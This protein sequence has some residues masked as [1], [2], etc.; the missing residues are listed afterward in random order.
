MIQR[1]VDERAAQLAR[2]LVST[3]RE[4][5]IAL[6][7][8]LAEEIAGGALA[9]ALLHI[10]DEMMKRVGPVPAPKQ[11]ARVCQAGPWESSAAWM[12]ENLYPKPPA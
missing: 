6:G 2:K 11:L 1:P 5:T 9:M 7:P 10:M 3:C 12:R 4:D 8:D